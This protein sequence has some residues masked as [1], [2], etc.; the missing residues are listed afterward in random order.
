MTSLST[1]KIRRHLYFGNFYFVTL[2][3]SLSMP[4][5]V[6]NLDA[7]S[8]FADSYFS[9]LALLNLYLY[10]MYLSVWMN[11]YYV[12]VKKSI[13]DNRPSKI[14]I[15]IYYMLYYTSNILFYYISVIWISKNCIKLNHRKLDRFFLSSHPKWNRTASN[16]IFGSDEFLPQNWSNLNHEHLKVNW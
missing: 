1:M 12:F 15:L 7:V 3:V 8:L 4:F 10:L 14:L 6:I 11:E 13:T 2:F 16:F 9:F 5:Y